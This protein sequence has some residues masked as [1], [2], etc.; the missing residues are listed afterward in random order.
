MTFFVMRK[1]SPKIK[2]GTFWYWNSTPT[3]SGIRRQLE[4]IAAAGYSCVYIHPMPD[5]FH[6]HNFFC[7]MKCSYLGKKFFSLMKY[8]LEESK[9]LGLYFMLYDEG[10][11]PSGSVLDTLVKKYPEC[12]AKVVE[13]KEDGSYKETFLDFPDQFRAEPVRRFIEMTHELYKREL[14]G[15]FGKSI[16]GIFTDEP[17]LRL[18]LAYPGIVVND[19][20]ISLHKTL[21]QK[22]FYRD[23]LPCVG[24][25]KADTPDGE[26]ARRI[27]NDVCSRL[28]KKHYCEQL[29]KWC[30]ENNL[31][32]EGHFSGEDDYLS[33]GATGNLLRVLSPFHVPGVD[34]IW[35][36]IY[37]EHPYSFFPR[38]A[39]SAAM[40]MKRIQTLCE[41]FNVYTYAISP[42]VMNFVANTLL[43]Q[44]IN[45]ILPMPY[46]Y[47]D[48]GKYK[49]CCS[50]DISPRTPAYDAMKTLNDFWEF[51]ADFDAGALDPDVWFFTQCPLPG[52]EYENKPR[53]EA[54]KLYNSRITAA[55]D[56]LDL[57]AVFW[58]FADEDDRDSKHLP[59]LLI[60]PE[61]D[62]LTEHQKEVI[63]YWKSRGV[64]VVKDPAEADLKK[65]A[66][67]DVSEDNVCRILPCVRP[68]G[69][70]VMVFNPS[71]SD[72]V[73]SFNSDKEYTLLENS[74]ADTVY[75]L[76]KRGNSYRLAVPAHSL[77]IL[78]ESAYIENNR[79]FD[80]IPV[81]L[82][83]QVVGTEKLRMSLEG[84]TKY[85]KR[86]A[87]V[88]LPASGNYCELEKDFSGRLVIKSE[89]VSDCD[90]EAYIQFEKVDFFAS[91]AVNNVDCG[92]SAFAPY[93]Y[94]VKLEKG[95]NKLEM[96]VSGT[97]GNEFRRCF[98]EELE[99]AGYFNVYAKRF[100]LYKI[101]DD[102]CGVSN[103]VILIKERNK[104]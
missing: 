54:Q 78:L 53:S 96:K 60:V 15:E 21:H 31:D 46:M 73:F 18:R 28:F 103:R 86:K 14:G 80:F 68:E 63:E 26:N 99:P 3:L 39:S 79:K 50:T 42:K 91:L 27:Y 37:P 89:L 47:R 25:F 92:S 98:K 82:D 40:R 69:R 93:L 38:F 45:R 29:A 101:D 70:A 35:R 1:S 48:T 16:R 66:E 76:E 100:M 75:P 22:D 49:I 41:A 58:R 88:K 94:K 36:Q 55:C 74:A 65:Y 12:R 57:N 72:T 52:M 13:L 33:G 102:K 84:N 83:W 61:P 62:S 51:A 8:A 11:W 97:A 6:K 9:R 19:E 17:F 90:C 67:F 87:D 104:K 64:A 4:S 5:E 23:I 10:G 59:R 2:T 44:G 85:E 32:L 43:V 77:R 7:G 71:E 81:A 95:V 34:S 30:E 56:T 24:L 20:I